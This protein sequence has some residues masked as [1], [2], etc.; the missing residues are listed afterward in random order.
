M[1]ETVSNEKAPK[2]SFIKGLK[3]EFKKIV[4]PDKA[5]LTQQ[6]G[7]VIVTSVVSGA[8]IAVLVLIIEFGLNIIIG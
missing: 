6:T 4:W 2:K 5:T 8:I 7:I 1:G 3:V